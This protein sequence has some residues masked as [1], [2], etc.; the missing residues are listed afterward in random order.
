MVVGYH[1]F[2]NPHLPLTIP[3]SLES[4]KSMLWKKSSPFDFLWRQKN[5]F[6]TTKK[7]TANYPQPH[8]TPPK[9][10]KC[11]LH[12]DW[13]DWSWWLMM[14]MMMM[15]MMMNMMN[16]ISITMTIKSPHW[17]C[18]GFFWRVF[19]PKSTSKDHVLLLLQLLLLFRH[20]PAPWWGNGGRLGENNVDTQKIGTNDVNFGGEDD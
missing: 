17:K 8:G 16:N 3:S 20:I 15:M 12:I 10:N 1:H 2:R 4:F 5:M 7:S 14:M 9:L 18:L 6:L 13:S 19:V 11:R